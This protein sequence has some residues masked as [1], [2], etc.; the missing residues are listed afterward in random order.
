[1]YLPNQRDRYFAV[2]TRYSDIDWTDFRKVV[3]AFQRQLEYWY[4]LP[5][6]ELTKESH[7]GFTVAALACLLG[8]CL[9][10]YEKGNL[11]SDRNTFIGYFRRHCP[12]LA[13]VF[14]IPITTSSKNS[15]K[16]GAEAL[17]FGLRCGVFHEAHTMLYVGLIRQNTVVEY[18][19]KGFASY[20]T[21]GDCPVVT[22]DPERL[23]DFVHARFNAYI[24]ELT[25]ALPTYDP[26]RANFKKKFERSFGV[27]ISITL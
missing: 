19:T 10:Q 14:P 11:K 22:F 9:S 5:T 26:L 2:E 23:F 24:I 17:Y 25:T 6:L 15:I 4:I 20:T 3:D 27:T 8:D 7:F 12:E 1:M 21:G 13:N 18:H 16:D